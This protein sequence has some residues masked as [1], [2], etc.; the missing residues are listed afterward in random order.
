MVPTDW[1]EKTLRDLALINYGKSAK[2]VISID[3]LFPVLGTGGEDRTG[4]QYLYDG[5]SIILGRKGSIDRVLFAT[6]KFWVIDTAYFLSDFNGADPRWLY[7]YLSTINLAG[8]NEATGVPSLARDRLY[9]ITIQRPTSPEQLEIAEIV[10]TVDIA[11]ERT[12]ALIAKQRRIKTGLMHDLLTR[13]IDEN[14]NVRSESTHEFKDSPVGRIPG[15][16]EISSLGKLADFRSGYAFKNHELSE[17]G[18]RIVRISNLHKKDFPYWHYDG[19]IHQNWIVREGDLLFSWAGVA[20]SIDC[21]LYVGPDALMNQHIYDF[22]FPSN[23][24]KLY[25]HHY[26]QFY[27]PRLRTEIEGGAG[28]LHL[29]KAKIQA[30]PI[31]LPD[32]EE[33]GRTLSAI[34]CMDNAMAAAQGELAKLG[35]MKAGLMQDLLTGKKRVTQLLELAEAH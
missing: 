13:G 16:W 29:T 9:K 7:Y 23:D 28:Q 19:A 8:L 33:I 22:V 6:G 26:L 2:D 5:E 1:E 24:L 11:I 25:V 20:S 12:E 34:T 35:S 27:L 17:F 4:D 21:N 3:G 18:W 30:I 32:P 10:V 15:G 14:G 31:P